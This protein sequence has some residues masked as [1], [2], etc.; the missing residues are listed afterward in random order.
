MCDFLFASRTGRLA[1]FSSVAFVGGS[2]L[3]SRSPTKSACGSTAML[4]WTK[5]VAVS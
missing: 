1:T 3:T 4:R 5:E 2:L